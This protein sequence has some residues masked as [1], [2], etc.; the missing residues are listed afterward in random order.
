MVGSG[1]GVTVEEDGG[2]S[3]EE[4]TRRRGR[5]LDLTVGA[6]AM[7]GMLS[8]YMSCNNDLH[9]LRVTCTMSS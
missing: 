8:L 3:R 1:E 2:G 5:H 9:E 6:V 7:T 4:E